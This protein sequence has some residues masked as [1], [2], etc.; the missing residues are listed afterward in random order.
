VPQAKAVSRSREL[1]ALGWL[2]F[3]RHPEGLA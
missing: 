3:C 2:W 1:M